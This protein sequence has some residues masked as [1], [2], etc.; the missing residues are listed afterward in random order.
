MPVLRVNSGFAKQ[1]DRP[2]AVTLYLPM[3]ENR[4]I[5]SFWAFAKWTVWELLC[6]SAE[7]LS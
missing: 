4:A 2:K 7:W 1:K 3:P 6:S 5:I